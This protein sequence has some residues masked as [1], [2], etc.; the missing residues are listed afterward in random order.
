[1]NF[2]VVYKSQN[3]WFGVA[4]ARDVSLIVACSQPGL[5][6]E[7][8]S[9]CGLGSMTHKVNTTDNSQWKPECHHY[10]H[11]ILITV[12]VPFITNMGGNAG[13]YGSCLL[14]WLVLTT[15]ISC[16]QWEAC[17]AIVVTSAWIVTAKAWNSIS[18]IV[19][20]VSI[21]NQTWCKTLCYCIVCDVL[22]YQEHD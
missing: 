4:G 5:S 6:T 22:K 12:A 9:W 13:C 18:C 7:V 21:L 20:E 16:C 3:C 11:E 17:S 8:A 2:R 15:C 1:M 19:C 14:H 10:I